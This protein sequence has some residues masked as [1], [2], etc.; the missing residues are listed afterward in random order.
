MRVDKKFYVAKSSQQKQLS[1]A[2]PISESDE[3]SGPGNLTEPKK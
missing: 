1:E 2:G 3:E